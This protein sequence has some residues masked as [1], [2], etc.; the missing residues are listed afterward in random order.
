MKPKC[1]ESQPIANA[2]GVPPYNMG[3]QQ[4]GLRGVP[5]EILYCLAINLGSSGGH[6]GRP[7]S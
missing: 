6:G 5:I 2:Q 4:I 1:Q 3:L 7:N